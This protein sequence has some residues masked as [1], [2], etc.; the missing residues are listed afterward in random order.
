MKE[1]QILVLGGPIVQYHDFAEIGPVLRE[2]ILAAGFFPVLSEDT[3][4]L[5]S[6]NIQAYHGILLCSSGYELS[7]EQEKGLL[8]AIIGF[9]GE[10]KGRGLI[11]LHG[12][13]V[14]FGNSLA[15]QRMIGARFLT[16]PE[17]AHISISLANKNHPVLDQVDNFIIHDEFYML[18]YFPP[19]KEL[20]FGHY[21]EFSLPLAWIKPYGLGRVFSL[22][23]GHGKEQLN[24]ASMISLLRNGLK[25]SLGSEL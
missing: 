23:L 1:K 9:P 16:H 13:A 19:F 12:A 15:Y 5:V 8:Q 7:P 25:W 10:E 4:E 11:A 2:I 3:S 17:M 18:E 22:M 14:S 21:G 6:E 20:L 24:H